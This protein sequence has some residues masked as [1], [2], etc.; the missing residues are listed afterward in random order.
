[1]V[2]QSTKETL[3]KPGSSIAVEL[4]FYH[5]FETMVGAHCV[6]DEDEGGFTVHWLDA[7]CWARGRVRVYMTQRVCQPFSRERER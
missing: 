2:Q 6:R 4:I 3:K 7:F 5:F 1:M